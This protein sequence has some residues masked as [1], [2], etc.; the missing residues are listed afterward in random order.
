MRSLCVLLAAM[1]ASAAP[2]AAQPVTTVDVELASFKFTPST[3]MLDHG[4]DYILRL[5]NTSS[6][7]HDF[8][9]KSFF[10]AAAITPADRDRVRKGGVDVAGGETVQLRLTAPRA[11]RYPV[12]CSHFMHSAFGMKGEILVR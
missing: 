11:G 4:R 2:G 3:V 12:H 10:D 7:G 9:A 6:G 5:H 8:V 1:L